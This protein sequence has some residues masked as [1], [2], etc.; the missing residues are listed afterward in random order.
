MILLLRRRFL[1]IDLGAPLQK[2][3]QSGLYAGLVVCA[4][5]WLLVVFIC[6]RTVLQETMA[7]NWVPL[8]L[9]CAGVRFCGVAQRI[10]VLNAPFQQRS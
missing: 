9:L 2:R 7:S 8:P 1:R 3:L 10:V 4:V 5:V 6:I